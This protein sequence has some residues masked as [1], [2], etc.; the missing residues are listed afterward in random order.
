MN[1]KFLNDMILSFLNED[2]GYLGDISSAA[3]PDNLSNRAVLIA[4]ENF[5]LCGSPFVNRLFKLYD[6]AS[7]LKWN[8]QDGDRVKA[9]DIVCEIDARTKT[10]LACERLSLNLLQSLSGIATNT[11]MYVKVLDG[12][13]TKVLDTRKTTPGF[14]LL[15]KYATRVG[16][17][18]NHRMGL[19]DAAMIKDNHIKAYGS[20][21]KA[22]KTVK[23]YLPV[24]TKI[25]V[26][27]EDMEELNEVLSIPDN[28]DIV[29]LDN[30]SEDDL[31]E[32]ISA[33]RQKATHVKI[34]VSGN[35]DIQKLERLR[36]FDIDFISTS[37]LITASKWVDISLE[38]L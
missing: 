31:A 21:I 15:E 7:T 17:A 25:E 23:Q 28:V 24:T 33:I 18:F 8:F 13:N 22:V 34:E 5:I 3:L 27:V 4:N 26:E 32:A 20:I 11:K 9:R 2:L 30:F 14:R 6:K 1:N 38:I 37:K 12:S 16:G 36:N 10:I 35:V 29:M 19:Y